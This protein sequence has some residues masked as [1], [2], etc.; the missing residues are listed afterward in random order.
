MINR[1]ALRR[2]GER[3]TTWS[4]IGVGGSSA[5][6]IAAV[7]ANEGLLWWPALLIGAVSGVLFLY[8]MIVGGR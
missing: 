8:S 5:F 3:A 7:W 4:D 6:A 2:S 1:Q